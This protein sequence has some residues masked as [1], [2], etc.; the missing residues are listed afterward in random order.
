MDVGQSYIKEQNKQFQHHHVQHY[1][2]YHAVG[3]VHL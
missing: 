3:R 2:V 1:H